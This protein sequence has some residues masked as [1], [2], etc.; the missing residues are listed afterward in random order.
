[1]DSADLDGDVETAMPLKLRPD[2][3]GPP[4]EGWEPPERSAPLPKERRAV[5]DRSHVGELRPSQL[6]HTYGVG[7]TVELPELTT[8]VL[9]L[10]DWPRALGEPSRSRGCSRP[11]GGGRLASRAAADAA[12]VPDGDSSGVPV[13]PFPR[14]L[15]CPC[16]AAWRRSTRRV[17]AQAE[18]WRPSDP[19]R[20]RRMPRTRSTRP[21]TAFPARYLMAC[22][23][24]HL[25]DFPWVEFLHGGAPSRAR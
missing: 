7:A 14:W 22:Q 25:D 8:L 23:D 13:A 19:L 17:H 6:M 21:P 9:G 12:V 20:A 4:A 24:G 5:R 16:A 18:P 11:C 10:E 15:R 3:I 1:M 2:G